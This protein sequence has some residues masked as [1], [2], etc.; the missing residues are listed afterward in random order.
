MQVD[1]E[2]KNATGKNMPGMRR[3]LLRLTYMRL[4]AFVA[5]E[6]I[7]GGIEKRGR[8]PLCG[9]SP[10]KNESF[11]RLF[12]TG[13][14]TMTFGR[15]KLRSKSAQGKVRVKGKEIAGKEKYG[16]P[17]GRIFLKNRLPSGLQCVTASG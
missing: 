9:L 16:E 13:F 15:V 14:K 11:P 4:F 8:S 5:G 3:F 17:H 12:E 7:N 2:Q 10:F 6:A 1:S